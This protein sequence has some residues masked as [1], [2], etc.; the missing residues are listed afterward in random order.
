MTD[1]AISV[2]E[3]AKAFGSQQVLSDVSFEVRTGETFALLGTN[4][5]GKTTTI[6]VL[7]GLLPADAGEVRVAGFDPAKSPIELRRSVGYLAE[8]Q[9]MYGWM[10]A[11]ELCRFLRPFYPTWDTR[12]ADMLLDGFEIP[13]ATRIEYLSKGQTV[14]LGLTVA[15]A[16]RPEIAILDDPALGLDPIA[17]KQFSRDLVEHLQS[18]GSTVLYSSHLLHEVEAVADTIAILHG[19]RIVRQAEADKLRGQVKQITLP[20]DV[21]LDDSP[22]LL[23]LRSDGGRTVVTLDEA[24]RLIA[25]LESDDIPHEVADLTLDEIFV[26]YVIGRHQNRSATED[27]DRI[28][29]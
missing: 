11:V 10:T 29:V 5:A 27:S 9:T 14:K 20:A 22:G 23:D 7:L 28:T 25:R 13:R 1:A 2:C 6:Q 16:H 8:D 24:P 3:L 19:G 15:L 21:R 12:L 4:G 17:R 18:S 26:A